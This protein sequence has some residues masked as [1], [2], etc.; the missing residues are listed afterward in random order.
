MKMLEDVAKVHP[1]VHALSITVKA[2]CMLEVKRHSNEEKVH[3]MYNEMLSMLMILEPLQHIIPNSTNCNNNKPIEIHMHDLIEQA[4]QD[5]IDCANLCDVYANSGRLEKVLKVMLWESILTSYIRRFTKQRE[6]FRFVLSAHILVRVESFGHKTD[7]RTDELMDVFN[8]RTDQILDFIK[9]YIPEDRRDLHDEIN[10][11]GG[12]VAITSDENALRELIALDINSRNNHQFRCKPTACARDITEDIKRNLRDPESALSDNMESFQRKLELQRDQIMREAEQA[13]HTECKRVASA[14][15]NELPHNRLINEDLRKIWE[16]MHW[17]GSVKARHLVL[18]LRDHY[19]EQA[20]E[21]KRHAK[22]GKFLPNPDAWALEW[23]NVKRIQPIIEAV[24]D[25]ASGYVTISKINRFTEARPQF[26]SLLHWIAFWAIGNTSTLY[27][28]RIHALFGEMFKLKSSVHDANRYIVDEYLN[29]IWQPVTLLTSSLQSLALP[30]NVQAR[31]QDYIEAEEQ[32]LWKL[33]QRVQYHLD[34]QNTLLLV[35]GLGRIEQYLMP[36]LYLLMRRDLSIMRVSQ[37]KAIDQRELRDS[38]HSIWTV[39]SAVN[40]RYQDLEDTFTQQNLDP[41]QQFKH[42]FCRLY[43]HYHNPN[44]LFERGKIRDLGISPLRRN[45]SNASSW[46]ESD[47]QLRYGHITF[48]QNELDFAAY[49]S[50]ENHP[51]N[52]DYCSEIRALLGRWSGYLYNSTGSPL[53]PM[54]SFDIYRS[55][56]DRLQVHASGTMYSSLIAESF[57]LVG[58][59][60]VVSEC[61][62]GYAFAMQ[63]TSSPP[64]SRSLR[65]YISGD[66]MSFA[67]IWVGHLGLSGSFF[68]SRLQPEVLVCRPLP[69]C[70]QQ[71]RYRALWKFAI[72]AAH[73]QVTRNRLTRSSI[74]RRRKMRRRYMELFFRTEL[75]RPLDKDEQEE[76]AYC[77]Q[78][79]YPQD[80][81]FYQSVLELKARETFQHGIVCDSCHAPICGARLVCLDCDVVEESIN[82]I[83]LCEDF[84]CAG[85]CIAPDQRADLVSSHLP[86]HTVIKTRISIHSCDLVTLETRAKSTLAGVQAAI[87]DSEGDRPGLGVATS[88]RLRCNNCEEHIIKSCWTCITC[89]GEHTPHEQTHPLVRYHLKEMDT[90]SSFSQES[91]KLSDESFP[92]VSAVDAR[93]SQMEKRIAQVDE[94]LVRMEELLETLLSRLTL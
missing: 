3:A 71:N 12:P 46:T 78:A 36:L 77:R 86:T 8:R 94:R 9:T 69:T 33:L 91:T 45:S 15:Q 73:N 80:A 18:A 67:G 53:A 1:F 82:T 88:N 2:V 62:I 55:D 30:E 38:V 72:A 89:D 60:D 58:G 93:M 23:I 11:R 34:D 35:T 42:T 16:E 28:D 54:V 24:D 65:G 22:E 63:T 76:L 51:V 7:Q 25:D 83:N 17:R 31:F 79:M 19:N 26:W 64:T 40:S 44:V 41:S 14:F 29:D 50:I 20:E 92:R 47:V 85:A 10:R 81:R 90:T 13:A 49:D 74:C 66:G 59:F 39:L 70:F 4:H 6:D 56:T 5:I 27:R 21:E 43:D 87:D 32:R 84:R 61:R 37:S 75:G 48:T 52:E 57:A 68:F